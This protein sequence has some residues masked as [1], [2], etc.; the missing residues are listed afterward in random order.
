M[1]KAIF[2]PSAILGLILILVYWYRCGKANKE[3]NQAVMVNAVLQSS[4]IICG[5][6]L[7]AGTL[8][9]E[10]RKLLNEIDLYIFI[11][12]LVVVAASVKGIHKDIFISTK[13]RNEQS[14]SSNK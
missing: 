4:G 12:G 14:K 10:A 3:F 9:E 6:L 8:N 13:V 1:D 11:S 2:I 5:L 7:V